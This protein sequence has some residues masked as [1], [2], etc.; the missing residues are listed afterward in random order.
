[1]I[2]LLYGIIVASTI[3]GQDSTILNRPAY[4]LRVAVDGNSFYEANIESSPYVLPDKTVQLYPGESVFIEVDQKDGK[5]GGLYATRE[6]RDSSKTLIISFSQETTGNVHKMMM[7]KVK[8]PL[9]YRLKYSAK[10]LT[11]RNKWVNT[12]VLP[13]E[14][15]LFGI[16][17]WPNVIVSIALGGWELEGR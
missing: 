6:I 11:L 12:D 13:V 2:L 3:F 17:T 15:G 14:S 9:P 16:E 4:K 7:L 5:I 10:M 8:N 1:M